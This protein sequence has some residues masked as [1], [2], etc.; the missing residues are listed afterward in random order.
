MVTGS[1]AV[2]IRGWDAGSSHGDIKFK[3]TPGPDI[4]LDGQVI[5]EPST[6][7][8]IFGGVAL[9]GVLVWKRR[10]RAKLVSE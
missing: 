6:Y 8:L 7:A 3:G 5:P 4:V 10:L 2:R 9:G 1:A